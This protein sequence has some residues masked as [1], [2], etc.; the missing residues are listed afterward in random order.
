MAER[1]LAERPAMQLVGLDDDAT[2]AATP[3]PSAPERLHAAASGARTWASHRPAT[4]G[5]VTLAVVALLAGVVLAGPRWL[6]ERA[7]AQVLGPAAFAG[8]VDSL[9]AAPEAL[10]A[11]SVDGGDAPLLVGDV[12]VV[13]AGSV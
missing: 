10:W 7:R 8:A 12:L 11:A 9:R 13:T 1:R 5:V 3:V 2:D 4:A 6:V